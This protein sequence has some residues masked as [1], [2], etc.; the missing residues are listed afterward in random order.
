MPLCKRDSGIR[1]LVHLILLSQYAAEAKAR[2]SV[3]G[4]SEPAAE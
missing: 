2:F 1:V 4:W 3:L